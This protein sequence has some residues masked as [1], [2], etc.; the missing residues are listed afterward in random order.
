M[1]YATPTDLSARFDEAIIKDLASDTGDPVDNITTDT[2]VLAALDDASGRIESA[3]TVSRLY[4]PDD[5]AGL[6]GNTLALL[7]RITCELAMAYLMGRR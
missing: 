5:L 3:C 2:K 7:K 4:S 6:T 1:A